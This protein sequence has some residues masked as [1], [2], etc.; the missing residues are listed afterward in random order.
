MWPRFHCIEILLD[1]KGK[2]CSRLAQVTEF[3][4]IRKMG[5]S[6]EEDMDIRHICL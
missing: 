2:Y 5:M 1:D 3:G 6:V 4:F